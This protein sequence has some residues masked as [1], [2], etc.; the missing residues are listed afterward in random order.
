MKQVIYFTKIMLL[1]AALS[2]FCSLAALD[3]TSPPLQTG[4]SVE[5]NIM[6][7]IDDSGSM[8]W[9]ITPD[10]YADNPHYVYPRVTGIYGDSDA[11]HQVV[12]FRDESNATNLNAANN[13]EA[14]F[15]RALRS[16]A[17]NKSYYNPSITYKPW[18][19]ADGTSYPNSN[20]AALCAF[21]V[22]ALFIWISLRSIISWLLLLIN[23]ISKP[24]M[25]VVC[26]IELAKTITSS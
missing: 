25:G 7:M 22:L 6:F 21:F 3:L 11:T 17:L 18:I 24:E 8:H 16:Y 19:K 10:L 14:L 1:S 5:P 4:S 9:E 13:N 12:S 15:A 26:M 2:S 20:P 23:L